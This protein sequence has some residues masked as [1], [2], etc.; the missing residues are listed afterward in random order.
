MAEPLRNPQELQRQLVEFQETQRQLQLMAAQ[1]QQL[2]LQVEEIK[3]AE[4]ELSK[5]DKGIYRAIGPLLIE[6]TKSEAS[7]DLKNRKELFEMRAGILAKQEEKLKPKLNELRN[8]LE[9]AIREG[10]TK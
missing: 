3:P 6:T 7:E 10:K 8:A 2:L 1:R 4:Q 9:K 5:C